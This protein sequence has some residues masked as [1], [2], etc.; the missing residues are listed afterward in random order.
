M[1]L[2]F[3]VERSTHFLYAGLRSPLIRWRRPGGLPLPPGHSVSGG[4]LYIPRITAEYQGEYQCIVTSE[5]GDY[6]SSVI[7]IVSGM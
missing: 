7:L 4:Q 1:L 5:R 2:E 3:L 6:S